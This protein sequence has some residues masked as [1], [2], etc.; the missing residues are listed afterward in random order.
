MRVDAGRGEGDSLDRC[1][2]GLLPEAIVVA[3][4]R[5]ARAVP[6]DSDFFGPARAR[7]RPIFV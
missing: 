2:P 5:A 7:V 3:D 4:G 6:D 1:L